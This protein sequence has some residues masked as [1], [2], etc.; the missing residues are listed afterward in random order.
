M[1]ESFKHRGLERYFLRGTKSGVP[2]ELASRIRLVLG[3]L[4]AS[5]ALKDMNLPGLVL[6]EL[7]GNRKGTWSVRVSGNWRITFRFY[8]VNAID[9]DLEDYH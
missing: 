4:H 5:E 6:H 8:G 3:R 1:I 9:V 2:P 7:K